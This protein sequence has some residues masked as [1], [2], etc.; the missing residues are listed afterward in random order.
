MFDFTSARLRH[1]TW[2]FATGTAKLQKGSAAAMLHCNSKAS[3][4]GCPSTV[5]TVI[6]PVLKAFL[7]SEEMSKEHFTHAPLEYIT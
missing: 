6:D 2:W 3:R 7:L 1:A 5:Q 4:L